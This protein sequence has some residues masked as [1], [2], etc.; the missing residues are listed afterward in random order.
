[1]FTPDKVILIAPE[2][3]SNGS[4]YQLQILASP[5]FFYVTADKLYLLQQSNQPNSCIIN[6]YLSANTKIYLF[7][8]FDALFLLIPHLFN[9]PESFCLFDDILND[10]KLS[11]IKELN[12]EQ[13]KIERI[14]DV[15]AFEGNL[16]IR[17]N[18]EKF[19][20]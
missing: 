3:L 8:P 6:N 19:K 12:K 16:Y 10:S 20:E 13:F 5:K 1:M 9:K 15:K 11:L 2:G 7:T 4:I 17:I 14:C 18:E